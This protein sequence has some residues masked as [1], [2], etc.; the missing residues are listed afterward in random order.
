MLERLFE[1]HQLIGREGAEGLAAFGAVGNARGPGHEK[2]AGQRFLIAVDAD[3]L[4][5]GQAV[6]GLVDGAALAGDH[7]LDVEHV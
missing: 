6:P 3:L 5:V 7:V 1:D 2:G 4:I